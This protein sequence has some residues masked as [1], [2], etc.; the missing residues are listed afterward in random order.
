MNAILFWLCVI[1]IVYT[2]AGYPILLA[3]CARWKKQPAPF[4]PFTPSLT[5]LIAAHNEENAIRAKLENSLALDY[6]RDCLQILVTADGSDDRT[7]EIVSEFAERGVELAYAPQRLGKMAAINRAMPLARGE[8]IVFSDANN[9]YNREALREL[10]TPFSDPTVGVV[11]GAKSVASG[12]G[13]LGESEG[14]YWRYESFIKKQ[15]TRLGCCTGVSGE[16]L[17]IRRA[18]FERLPDEIINDDF[19]M[20]MRIVRRGY[21]AIYVPRARSTERVSLSAQDEIVRRARIIAG[22]YQ[23]IAHALEWLPFDQPRVVW[24]IVSHKFLRPLVPLAMLGALAT[25]LRAV[26]LPATTDHPIVGLG[27]PVNWIFLIAQLGFYTLAL[28]GNRLASIT[29]DRLPL[30][31]Y[32]PTFLVNS[33]VAALIGLARFLTGRQTTAWQRARR[34]EDALASK[35]SLKTKVEK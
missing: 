25:N 16:I 7:P 8:V 13:V 4:K 29:N 3:V 6:P 26:I 27:A 21:R 10:A 23:A 28:V 17:A 2:Y 12:D 35:R 9:L 33:N 18:L 15:E 5:L 24:Q 32:L 22:R 31:L 11:S 34:R 1:A 30:W 20:T 19:Y 14:A